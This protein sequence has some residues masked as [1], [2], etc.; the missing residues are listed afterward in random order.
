[1]R[2]CHARS[3][4]CACSSHCSAAFQWE[5]AASSRSSGRTAGGISIIRQVLPP[6]LPVRLQHSCSGCGSC[7]ACYCT[8][9]P[10]PCCASFFCLLAACTDTISDQEAVLEMQWSQYLLLVWSV[11]VSQNLA[12]RYRSYTAEQLL[13]AQMVMSTHA[14]YTACLLPHKAMRNFVLMSSCIMML[15]GCAGR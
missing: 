9:Q 2:E 5:A 12:T 10:Q 13:T 11:P 3:S 6:E 14:L 7:S 8:V 1:M 15:V 4:R